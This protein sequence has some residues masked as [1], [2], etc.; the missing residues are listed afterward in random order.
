MSWHTLSVEETFVKYGTS[1][2]GLTDEEAQSRLAR[3]GPNELTEKGQVSPVVTFFRQFMSPLIYM[4]LI[5]TAISLLLGHLIDAAVIIA[6]VFLNAVV[7]F[8]QETKAEQAI[9]ALKEMAAPRAKIRREGQR[10]EIMAREI[11]PGD[12]ILLEVGDKVPADARLVEAA[13]LHV[14]ESALTGESAPVVKSTGTLPEEVPLAE[15]AN[16]V[17]MGTAVTYGRGVAVVTETGMNT[18]MGRIAASVETVTEEETPLQ[19]RMKQLTVTLG[20]LALGV[21]LAIFVGGLLRGYALFDMFLFTVATAVAAIPEGLPAIVTIVLALGVRRMAH[22][23]VIIRRLP[24]VETLGSATVICTDKTGTLT[25]NQMTVEKVFVDRTFIRVT[26]EGYCPAGHFWLDGRT[27]T[28][29]EEPS[30]DLLLRIAV[31][32]NDA[33]LKCSDTRCSIVG[34]PTEGALVVAAAKGGLQKEEMEKRWLRL[35]E[36]PF[37]AEL[38]Y[39]A[40]LNEVP[41]APHRHVVHIKGAPERLL[42]MCHNIYHNGQVIEL[43][44]D[45][46]RE[47]CRA[48]QSMAQDALRVLAFAYDELPEGQTSIS[49]EQLVAGLTFVGLTG[50][51]DPPREEARV[52]IGVAEEAGIKVAMITGDDPV[53]ARAIGSSL[54][55]NGR[56][57]TGSE[58]NRLDDRQLT[59][60]V[61]SVDIFARVTP[62]HKLRIVQALKRRNQIVAMTGDGVNDAP[63]LKTADIGVAMGVTGT[64]VAR[65]A[66]D[67]ILTDDNFASIVGAVEEGRV[68]FGNIRRV[69]FYLLST[70]AG[71]VITLGLALLVGL[72]LPL[73]AVQILFINLVTDAFYDIALGVEP[74][75]EQVLREPPRSPEEP[76]LSQGTFYRLGMVAGHMAVG[77]LALF[78]WQLQFA[79]LENARTVA[80]TTI[81]AFQW[82]NAF[83]ARSATVPLY[84]LGLLSNIWLPLAFIATATLQLVVLYVPF[85]QPVFGTEPPSFLDW[86]AI[87]LVSGSILLVEEIRKTLRPRLFS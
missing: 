29:S 48:H 43:T 47:V 17:W 65:E 59:D 80:F 56:V 27:V 30:L 64:D 22:R 12:I 26:G 53:T 33:H 84:R 49:P 76:V 3:F 14:D 31:L 75:H 51:I 24:A 69:V 72:P 50:M 1:A 86:L 82:F 9:R 52:A 4:L 38:G 77:T 57:M 10:Q 6:V 8:I 40:T 61:E 45:D 73:I 41:S 58:V 70:N 62:E 34:D 15:M 7:G 46:R 19:Q 28:P 16:T 37:N 42:E 2:Y 11:V 79:N 55:L 13:T 5:A 66:S 81:A 35:D 78:V 71:E 44:E 39:M 85:L 74:S 63:A 21:S 20:Y 23:H 18:E 83:N 32:A 67:M 25:K 36:V 87:A 54:G 60:L 68:I